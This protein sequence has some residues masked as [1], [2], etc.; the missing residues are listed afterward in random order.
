MYGAPSSTIQKLI[1][2]ISHDEMKHL[3][4]DSNLLNAIRD[5]GCEAEE[6]GPP[7]LDP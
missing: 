6:N 5:E 4:I 3:F 7:Y 2:G 1:R